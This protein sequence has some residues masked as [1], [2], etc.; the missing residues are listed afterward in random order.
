MSRKLVTVRKIEA[1]YPI[2]GA[3]LIE[4]VKVD[5]WSVVAQKGI[6]QVG[7]YV[8]YFEIDSFLPESDPRFESFM[9]FG[10]TEFEGVRGHR[11]KTKRMKGVYS[12]GIIM[13]VSE[14]FQDGEVFEM[15]VDYS[16]FIGVKKYEKKEV[17]GNC[18]DAKGTFPSFLVKSDQERIQNIYGKLKRDYENELF[19][20]TL[21]MDGSSVTVYCR[22]GEVGICSRNQELKYDP[23]IPFEDQDKF[24]QGALR[25]DL[26][27]KVKL[28]DQFYPN[29]GWAI[30]GELVGAGIQGGYEKFEQYEVF[31]Y[32]IF[33]IKNHKFLDYSTF[34][35]LTEV[36]NIQ[37]VP[38]IYSPEPILNKE[39]SE[40]LSMADGPGMRCKYR[41]GIVYK[42]LF[43]NCQFKVISNKYLDKTGN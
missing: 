30:Q 23:E 7:D 16:E 22:D 34:K 32:N 20:G 24:I 39:L 38:E 8:L 25:S 2:D 14:F 21:K 4:E 10:I 18:G 40:I 1:I 37:T 42:Q 41:E 26:F 27:K 15:D 31:A 6:H 17:V 43:G 9:K 3:D 12:Q 33:D 36:L 5:G 11:V 29:A 19:V 13:P 28:L 35:M